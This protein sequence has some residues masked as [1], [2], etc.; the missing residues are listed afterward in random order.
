DD[1]ARF[2]QVTDA[3]DDLGLGGLNVAAAERAQQFHLLEERLPRPSRQVAQDRLLDIRADALHR[4]RQ[5]RAVDGLDAELD[6][7][8]V[9]GGDVL[10]DEH[11]RPHLLGQ[12]GVDFGQAIE[13]LPLGGPVGVVE[14]L[15]QV[16][17]PAAARR[18]GAGHGPEPGLEGGL[19][20]LD[21]VGAGA[22]HAGDAQGH[23]TLE[24]GVEPRQH[25]GGIGGGLVGEDQPHRLG[26]LLL[27][28][29]HQLVGAH[30]A[31]P[32]E[33]PLG[34]AADDPVQHLGALWALPAGED[35]PSDMDAAGGDEAVAGHLLVDLA[36]DRV[37]HLRVDLSQAGHLAGEDL[38]FLFRQVPQHL[39]GVVRAHGND[40]SRRLLGRG[41]ILG[42]GEFAHLLS[43]SQLRS[44]A[45]ISSGWDWTRPTTSSW[46][47]G[48]AGSDSS[49]GAP[50]GNASRVGAGSRADWGETS[51]GRRRRLRPMKRKDRATISSRAAPAISVRCA[52]SGLGS[53]SSA[54]GASSEAG[55]GIA[56]TS[57]TSPRRVSRPTAA[58]T[59]RCTSSTGIG[60]APV[61]VPSS[62]TTATERR[63]MVPGA[64]VIDVTTRSTPYSRSVSFFVYS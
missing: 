44:N 4:H 50:T 62:T 11:R 21:H 31:Q 29:L 13:D 55:N 12:F 61:W 28:E 33:R 2:Y 27:E 48:S 16:L 52:S 40:E 46:M 23:V 9:E 14:H 42:S 63:S 19:H 18:I 47:F 17:H 45:A 25:L 41:Q 49:A 22:A 26:M 6:R 36:Q 24:V 64:S 51:T 54:T 32:G 34:A 35:L 3:Y 56:D 37:D 38:H 1:L 39:G 8:V 43:A 59:R 57:T 53:G 20:L 5:L 7:A 60:V 15:R 30:V 58:D 10:E